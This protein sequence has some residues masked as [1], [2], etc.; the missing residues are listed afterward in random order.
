MHPQYS[1]ILLHSAGY[2]PLH[3]SRIMSAALC[4]FSG[5]SFAQPSGFGAASLTCINWE[6]SIL[7]IH[8]SLLTIHSQ[9]GCF[10]LNQGTPAAVLYF[11]PAVLR[12]QYCSPLRKLRSVPVLRWLVEAA[13]P[14][15]RSSNNNNFRY[16]YNHYFLRCLGVFIAVSKS[17]SIN[18][19]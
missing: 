17:P 3:S 11:F 18:T 15:L 13:T 4:C 7:F 5:C 9:F 10:A 6:S 2:V 8:D 16:R 1:F 14:P 12:S 19:R